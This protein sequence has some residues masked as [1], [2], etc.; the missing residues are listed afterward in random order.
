[1]LRFWQAYPRGGQLV[2]SSAPAC[3]P[4]RSV[5]LLPSL[6]ETNSSPRYAYTCYSSFL[7]WTTTLTAQGKHQW[8]RLI[9]R[10]QITEAQ[11]FQI[12]CA[13]H[14]PHHWHPFSPLLQPRYMVASPELHSLMWA[15]SWV[16][17]VCCLRSAVMLRSP[18][19]CGRQMQEPSCLW[20]HLP[21]LRPFC[22]LILL[23]PT[24]TPTVWL[25]HATREAAWE[26]CTHG[27]LN[28]YTHRWLFA[29]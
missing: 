19:G 9:W 6:S 2:Q 23:L 24:C 15:T 11:P 12:S 20:W 7:L 25:Y 28:S 18:S 8:P 14:A 1:M 4:V 3:I 29:S 13:E 22:P 27:V 16:P 5:R 26:I 21:K 10:D 17:M